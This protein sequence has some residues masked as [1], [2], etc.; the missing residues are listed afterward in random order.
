MNDEFETW[1]HAAARAATAD[2]VP[3]PEDHILENM[4]DDGCEPDEVADSRI[5][6][7]Y[8]R[9]RGGRAQ[10][11]MDVGTILAEHRRHDA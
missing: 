3:L 2:G 7:R 5:I 6:A 8:V 10:S 1:R 11:R 4:F 9:A